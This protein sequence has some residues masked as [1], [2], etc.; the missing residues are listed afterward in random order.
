MIARWDGSRPRC[1]NAAHRS[2]QARAREAGR[3]GDALTNASPAGGPLILNGDLVLLQFPV[4]QFVGPR[5]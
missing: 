3:G 4:G 2:V 1:N 5:P